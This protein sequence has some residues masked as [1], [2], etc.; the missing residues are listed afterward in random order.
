MLTKR[1]PS[2]DSGLHTTAYLHSTAGTLTQ[3]CGLFRYIHAGPDAY[4]FAHPDSD[5]FRHAHSYSAPRYAD[6]GANPYESPYRYPHTYFYA[7][8]HLHSLAFGHTP[9]HP[10]S[11][12]DACSRLAETVQRHGRRPIRGELGKR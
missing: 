8:A 4:A 2:V 7:Y 12:S 9:A 10:D 1:P 5:S 6:D 3:D 11:N